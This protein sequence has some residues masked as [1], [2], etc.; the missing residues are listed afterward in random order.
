[1][2]IFGSISILSNKF[3]SINDYSA[4]LKSSSFWN[5]FI[6]ENCLLFQ[7]D[8]FCCGK[9]R[10]EFFSYNYLGALWNHEPCRIN[11]CRIGNGGTSFRKRS[12]MAKICEKYNGLGGDIAEDIFFAIF[13]KEDGL[14]DDAEREATIFS[15]ECIF[16]EKSIYGHQIY[17]SIA[18]RDLDGFIYNKI[19]KMLEGD[20]TN[21]SDI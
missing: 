1:L 11:N 21:D 9:F 15:F 3:S 8:S 14:L 7:Y 2:G 6:E 18:R 20:I 10:K 4:L 5:G 12:V 13:L 17:Q 16:S 19:Q